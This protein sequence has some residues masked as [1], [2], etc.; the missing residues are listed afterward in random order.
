MSFKNFAIAVLLLLVAIVLQFIIGNIFGLWI[1]LTFAALVA[2]TF[3]LGLAEILFAALIAVFALNWQPVWSWEIVVVSGLPLLLFLLR[4]RFP[5]QGWLV[6]LFFIFAGVVFFYLTFGALLIFMAPSV[7]L[8]DLLGSMLFGLAAFSILR[9][10][11]PA[12]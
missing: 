4:D 5:W 1:N 11:Q 8:L 2:T 9:K 6:N 10:V 12:R 7:F 3:F